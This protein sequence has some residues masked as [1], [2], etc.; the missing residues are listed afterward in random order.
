MLPDAL[1][2]ELAV[3]P[4]LRLL[5][6]PEELDRFSRDAYEYSPVLQQ[7]LADCRAELVVR[8][9]T[10]E[11]VVHVAAACRRHAVPLTLRGS[12]TGNYGQ[13]VPLES[14]V[15]MVMTQLRAVRSIDQASGVAV[16]ECGCLLKDLNREL[17]GFGRQLRLMPST[18]RSATIGGFIAGGSGGIGSVRWGFLRDPGHLLGL[19]VVTMEQEPQVLQLEACDAEALNHAYGTNGIITALRLA[20]A[21]RVDWQEV[22]VDC[23]D[24]ATAVELARRCSS[25]AIDLHLCTVLEAAVVELLP[26]WDL[27]QRRSDRLLLLV[28]PDAVST[29]QRLAAAVG[30]DLTHLGAE[31]DRQGN[32]LRELSWNHT[33]LHLRQRDPDWT[34][35]QMLLPQ[36]EINCLET[37]KQAWGDDLLWHLEGVRQQG[38]QRIA[39]LPLVRWRGV[40]AL[41]QLMQQCRDLGALIFN[42]HVLTV[43]GGGLG[44]VDG[45]QVATKHRYD[46][47]GLLNPGKLG[48]F[49]S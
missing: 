19:E 45:D 1:R 24:W 31:A 49:S 7:R 14:G 5:T 11:A 3:V 6:Q 4:G 28:A 30:A 15:V 46:P 37:L 2:T 12:G 38:A 34:Y 48:G 41:E 44:V 13:S 20:T 18:W 21:L 43:E 16:V 47:A 27:P 25:A 40:E 10:V 29:V 9:D 36:P 8:P 23:P 22:V 17:A 26:K 33:T 42:P 39:A 32:G 35:L